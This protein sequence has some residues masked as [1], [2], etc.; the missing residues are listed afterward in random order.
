MAY[1]NVDQSLIINTSSVIISL[2]RITV[3]LLAN[4]T[5]Q[6]NNN[7]QIRL[8]STLKL[9]T[10]STVVLRVKLYVSEINKSDRIFVL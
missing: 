2:Q 1:L 10:S 9:N 8:P 6:L 5:I 4:K 3:D 7:T